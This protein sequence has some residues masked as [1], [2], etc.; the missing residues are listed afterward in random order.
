VCRYIEMFRIEMLCS[1]KHRHVRNGVRSPIEYDPQ[2]RMRIK[3]VWDTHAN[4]PAVRK[5]HPSIRSSMIS[6]RL[7]KLGV[8]G[9]L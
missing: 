9:E 6:L 4:S 5:P 1:P 3:N 2:N 8:K 7:M